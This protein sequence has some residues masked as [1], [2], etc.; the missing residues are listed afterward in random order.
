MQ[1]TTTRAGKQ[2]RTFSITFLIQG[3]RYWVIPLHDID[4]A[5]ALKAY[6]LK[7]RD[8]GGQVIAVYD[9][10]QTPEGHVECDCPGHTR[11]GH[12]RH[13]QTLQAAGMLPR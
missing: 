1:S 4:P 12:C 5:V 3:T 13:Q 8:A 2:P 7:K 11:W 6:R 10:R 9:V